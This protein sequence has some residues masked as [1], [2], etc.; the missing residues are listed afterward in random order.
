MTEEDRVAVDRLEAI[1]RGERGCWVLV[2]AVQPYAALAGCAIE[3]DERITAE[4]DSA[5]LQRD[6]RVARDVDQPRSSGEVQPLVL[7]DDLLR[8]LDRPVA[9]AARREAIS[10]GADHVGSPAVADECALWV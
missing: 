8:C 3:V 2:E 7:V 6:R 9:P 4:D 1:E 10:E 5:L